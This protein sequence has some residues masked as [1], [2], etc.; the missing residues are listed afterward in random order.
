L[1]ITSARGTGSPRREF[2]HA[3]DLA[4]ACVFLMGNYDDPEV[5]NIGFGGDTTI[6]DL[7][8]IIGKSVGFEGDFA[9]DASKPDGAPRKLLDSSK[10][11]GMGWK[12][13]I[14]LEEGIR[15]TYRWYREHHGK[16]R[17]GL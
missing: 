1:S 5:I 16:D 17:K 10:I 8:E 13:Q 9:F 12:P 6:K 7:A 4:E 14:G 15:Q 3:D 2:L 11:R